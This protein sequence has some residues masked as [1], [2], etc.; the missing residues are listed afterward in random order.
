MKIL[1]AA[2]A[3]SADITTSRVIFTAGRHAVISERHFVIAIIDDKL[4]QVLRQK[5]I[6]SQKGVPTL[7]L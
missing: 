4:R 2:R 7:R 1:I 5:P 3:V 6:A